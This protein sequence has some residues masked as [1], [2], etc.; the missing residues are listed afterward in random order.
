[1]W[2]EIHPQTFELEISCIKQSLS[3]FVVWTIGSMKWKLLLL[4]LILAG[5]DMTSQWDKT[6]RFHSYHQTKRNEGKKVKTVNRPVIGLNRLESTSVQDQKTHLY[7]NPWFSKKSIWI[8]KTKEKKNIKQNSQYIHRKNISKS[9]V[10]QV[11]QYT[12][13]YESTWHS[14]WIPYWARA[15]LAALRS[16]FG[17]L[18]DVQSMPRQNDEPHGIENNENI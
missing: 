13:I 17:L 6:K 7:S 2:H 16:L 18:L 4:L 8:A 1:M 3:S 9:C 11:R 5:Q 10:L 15:H 14:P 12:R